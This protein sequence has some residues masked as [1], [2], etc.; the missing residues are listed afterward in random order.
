M[1]TELQLLET[2][3]LPYEAQHLKMLLEVAGID[4]FI[5]GINAS[6]TFGMNALMG[7][8]KIKVRA[9]DLPSARQV[10]REE[11]L[12]MS[13]SGEAW[14][15]GNCK[16]TNEPSFDICWKC[17]GAREE[18]QAER[19]TSQPPATERPTKEIVAEELVSPSP[20]RAPYNP[21]PYAPPQSEPELPP[22][23]DS[24]SSAAQEEY[25]ETI[26]RAYRA[27]ILGLITLPGVMHLYS[28]ILLLGALN[29][30]ADTT[31]RLSTRFTIAMAINLFVFLAIAGI[32]VFQVR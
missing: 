4:A 28:L 23:S 25:N 9:S 26:E 27:S 8:I 31:A 24:A 3:S 30:E 11:L 5:E 16:E 29:I 15:C 7:S 13:Q 2:V 32:F 14:Y 20:V 21:T 17:G 18:V 12:R 1:T 10:L 22:R 6:N 19:P